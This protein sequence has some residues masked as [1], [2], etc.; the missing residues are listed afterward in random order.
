MFMS[1][2]PGKFNLNSHI[3][4]QVT[5]RTLKLSHPKKARRVIFPHHLMIGKI[6]KVMKQ[7]KEILQQTGSCM[8]SAHCEISLCP[9][10]FYVARDIET[11]WKLHAP[12][13]GSF[14]Q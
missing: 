13:M 5:A 2:F 4:L 8:I 1:L 10:V 14:R 11:V 9:I 3:N 12:M 7:G 6:V